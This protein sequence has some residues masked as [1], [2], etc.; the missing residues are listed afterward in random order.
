MRKPH[1]NDGFLV[2]LGPIIS[3]LFS[4]SNEE[5]IKHKKTKGACSSPISM[6][7]TLS[8]ILSLNYS[9]FWHDH[10]QENGTEQN[11]SKHNN[12]TVLLSELIYCSVECQSDECHGAPFRRIYYCW[13]DEMASWQN[14][15]API[16]FSI[17]YLRMMF[18]RVRS[19]SLKDYK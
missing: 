2:L 9:L 16:F 1:F 8:S 13:V 19:L 18:S 17:Q 4:C 10:I 6:H 5:K 15:V 14:V 11:D 12:V 7:P 3:R